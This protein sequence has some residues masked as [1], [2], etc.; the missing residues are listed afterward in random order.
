MILRDYQEKAKQDIYNFLYK[1]KAK[2][3]VLVSPVGTGKSIYPS[4]I[5][6][7]VKCPVLVVQ[8]TEELLRQNLEK[9]HYFGLKPSVYSASMGSKEVSK[10]TY[11]T[12][13]SL[14]KHP[15]LFKNFK[16]VV[17]DEAH[18]NMTNQVKNKRISKKGKFNSFLEKINP[19]KIIG[20]TATLSLIHI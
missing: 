11:A 16:V 4:L 19:S 10:I 7:M 8:P 6:K 13:M 12:P 17:I 1:S 15:E 3:G 2:K 20:L 14:I 18:L 5:S 9:A